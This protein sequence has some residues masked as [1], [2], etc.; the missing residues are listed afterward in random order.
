M[1][2]GIIAAG[3]GSRL[4]QEGVEM[5]KPLVHLNGVPMLERLITIF[6][7]CGAESI[8]IIINPH[9]AEVRDY[10]G[11]LCCAAPLR[12]VEADT[13]SSMH[14]FYE[15]SRTI[16]FTHKFILTTVDTVFLPDEFSSYVRTFEHNQADIDALMGVTAFVDD[17]KPLYVSADPDKNITEFTDTKT[18]QTTFVSGG[19]YGLTP[20]AVRVLE[21]CID[22]GISRMRN[23][24][25]ALL[26]AGL[27]VKAFPFEKIIDVDHA[28]DIPKAESM[29]ASGGLNNSPQ[30]LI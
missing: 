10:L 28:D 22:S 18:A 24:Q 16:G 11:S 23:F 7:A 25:R 6:N 1:H 21:Q 9:M 26:T 12:V 30:C 2:Y 19:I 29:I 20:S 8:N 3:Q 5:P 17:E 14:S 4:R 15:L 13:P 27:R